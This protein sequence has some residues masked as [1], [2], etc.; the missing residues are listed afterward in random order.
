MSGIRIR[1][2]G[3]ALPA[4][5]LTNGELSRR[6]DTSDEWI[7]SRT[8]IRERRFVRSESHLSLCAQAARGALETAGLAPEQIGV[9]IV[10]TVSPDQIS[11]A[12]ACLLQKELGLPEDTVC[13]DLNAACS[14]F[15]FALHTAQ[16][17][18]AASER[19]FGLVVGGEV[20]SRLTDPDDRSTCILFGDGAGAAAVE[21]R[22]EWPSVSAVL[23]V[24]GDR[25]ILNVAGPNRPEPSYIRMEGRAVYK[26]AVETAPRCIAQ[27]LEKAGASA[28]DVDEL[29]LH[30][31]NERIIEAVAKRCGFP[32]EKCYRNV[33]K[34]GN[35]SA[36]SVP[37]ALDELREMGRLG[38]GKRALCA[39]FGG[40]LTWAG[41]LIAF[42]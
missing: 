12:S 14:G 16:Q 11:P 36:A 6:V 18:L 22:P 2:T 30:Q 7:V 37:I 39:A 31:A 19:P 40:G 27:V 4:G 32:P 33:A 5:V 34:Y 9:C 17:L 35:T 3:R 28:E 20:L 13:F 26:F 23:G 42:S 29:V 41:L 38:P 10:A 1:G 8:G 25:P 24:R 15:L 21:W